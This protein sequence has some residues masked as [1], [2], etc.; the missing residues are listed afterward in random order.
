MI[1]FYPIYTQPSHLYWYV[2]ACMA[3]DGSLAR[4]SATEPKTS[5]NDG[6]HIMQVSIEELDWKV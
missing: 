6:A 2:R 1:V 3:V 4:L 5:V